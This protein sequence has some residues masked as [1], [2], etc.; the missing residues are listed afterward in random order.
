MG[1]DERLPGDPGD[2]EDILSF[3]DWAL[4]DGGVP[5]PAGTGGREDA[6]PTLQD[7]AGSAAAPEDP[8]WA[9]VR[10]NF[11]SAFQVLDSD[12]R[13]TLR[14]R[15]LFTDEAFEAWDGSLADTATAGDVLLMRLTPLAA[16]HEVT[17]VAWAFAASEVPHLRRFGEE[18]LRRLREAEA[19][20]D[21]RRLWRVRGERFHH[22]AVERWSK[23]RLPELFTTT[24]EPVVFA[25]TRWAVLDRAAVEAALDAPANLAREG[26]APAW[27]WLG[28]GDGLAPGVPAQGVSIGE[29]VP[30]ARNL[31]YV[32]LDEG[33]SGPQLVLECMSEARLKAGRALVEGRAGRWLRFV[34]ERRESASEALA[35]ASSSSSAAAA[36]AEGTPP[37]ESDIPE[38]V[39]REVLERALRQYEERWLVTP[40]PALEGKTPREAAASADP[41]VRRRL[42]DLLL[43][44]E[45]HERR[46][47]RRGEAGFGGM[48]A[49]R[50]RAMLGRPR[51]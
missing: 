43:E 2:P 3:L 51:P 24:G 31:G 32:T 47:A 7:L 28:E 22:Y 27:R 50:L 40:V 33:G 30:G 1:L 42:D 41:L 20:A 19:D 18:E 16:A 12:G 35:A 10:Q 4:H 17:A 46:G 36:G 44:F 8:A 37:L 11:F 38:E 15:D 23:P 29:L 25:S 14:L 9:A 48:S 21:W 34:E 26:T 13:R 45:N 49:A 6:L 39:R 5:D